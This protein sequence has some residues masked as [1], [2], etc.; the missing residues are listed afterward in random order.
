MN[1]QPIATKRSRDKDYT[2]R[3]RMQEKKA[4]VSEHS[5]GRVSDATLFGDSTRCGAS[6]PSDVQG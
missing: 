4:L 1:S 3:K 5:G 2:N 6:V